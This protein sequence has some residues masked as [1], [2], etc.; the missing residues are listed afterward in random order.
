MRRNSAAL[1][2]LVILFCWLTVAVRSGSTQGFDD[3]V[4]RGI[5]AIASPPLTAFLRT[6]S[7]VC[8]TFF[9]GALGV[10]FSA[11][12][13]WQGRKR[14]SG[15][16]AVAVLG[17]VTLTNLLKLLVHRAR[18]EAFFETPLPGT[19]SFPSGHALFSSCILLAMAAVLTSNRWV[20]VFAACLVLTIGFSRIYLGVHYPTDVLGGYIAGLAWLAA[21]RLYLMRPTS[22]R[23]ESRT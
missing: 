1:V 14:E 22:A 8:N 23:V 18:P 13:W 10:A 21:M 12:L 6:I 9:T 11:A 7:L 16:L 17:A 5:P 3:A 19:Y 4:R 2:L 15:I 20:R